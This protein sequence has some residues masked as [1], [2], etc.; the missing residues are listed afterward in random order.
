MEVAGPQV[1]TAGERD[2]GQIGG[3]PLDGGI[4]EPETA[5]ATLAVLRTYVPRGGRLNAGL[6][7]TAP[8]GPRRTT[9]PL[10]G[11]GDVLC[12]TSTVIWLAELLKRGMKPVVS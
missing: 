10:M 6:A 1:A 11:W 9:V 3:D 5:G 2:V 4:A 8:E 7:I 12:S